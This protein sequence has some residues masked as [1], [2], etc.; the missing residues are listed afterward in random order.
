MAYSFFEKVVRH[1]MAQGHPANLADQAFEENRDFQYSR[2]SL[3]SLE[4]LD[5]FDAHVQ[6]LPKSTSP[7]KGNSDLWFESYH[8]TLVYRGC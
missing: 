8:T 7:Q 3:F 6:L 4:S 5:Y 1:R 2:L